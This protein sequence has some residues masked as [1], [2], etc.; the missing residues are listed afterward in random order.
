MSK[1]TKV[2]I[3]KS[4]N[5]V[6]AGRIRVVKNYRSDIGAVR[7]IKNSNGCTPVQLSNCQRYL[8]LISL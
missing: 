7:S 8:K 5:V 3:R 4:G 6:Y 2:T 1:L